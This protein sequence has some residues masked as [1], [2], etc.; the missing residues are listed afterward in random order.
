MKALYIFP[1]PDDESFGPGGCMYKQ[2][3]EGNDIYLL[4]LTKGGATKI[5][6]DLGMT[7]DEMGNIR[8]KEMQCVAHTLGLKGLTVLDLPDS[9]LKHMDPRIIEE[10]VRSEIKKIRPDVIVTYAVHGISGFH[11]H[12]VTHAVVKRV[13]AELKS[14]GNAPARLCFFTIDK[15]SAEKQTHFRLS[16]STD[17]EIVIK[18]KLEPGDLA[19]GKEALDCYVTYRDV[20][21]KAGISDQ[22]PDPVCFEVFDEKHEIIL[23]S[24]FQN[25]N[26]KK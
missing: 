21:K 5:R 15:D 3:R 8:E 1:H 11:D 24:I 13:F 4:T 7:V 14:E 23:N 19:K 9:G 18:E 25:L 2:S 6:F 26:N 10:A 22:L 17:E 12:L 16:H 20:I